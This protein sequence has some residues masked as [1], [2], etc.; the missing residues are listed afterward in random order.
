MKAWTAHLICGLII[1]AA[2][3]A[4]PAPQAAATSVEFQLTGATGSLVNNLEGIRVVL[5][6]LTTGR[7]QSAETNRQ[8]LARFPDVPPGDYQVR[9]SG[10][11]FQYYDYRKLDKPRASAIAYPFS[12]LATGAG[13]DERE[14]IATDREGAIGSLTHGGNLSD[15]DSSTDLINRRLRMH[16]IALQS[17]KKLALDTLTTDKW[18][19]Y[20]QGIID[21]CEDALEA[22]GVARRSA[23][24]LLGTWDM[25]PITIKN[26]ALCGN[27][28]YHAYVVVNQRVSET[29][30]VGFSPFN[31]DLSQADPECKF[32][33]HRQGTA[34]VDLFRQGNSIVIKYTY[35]GPNSYAD[36]RLTLQGYV[37]SGRDAS[38]EAIV[39][40]R[41]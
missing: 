30:Y 18:M 14:M 16:R 35:N 10:R 34:T 11:T 29:H 3:V 21:E 12:D 26:P 38:G 39:F 40:S 4:A 37:M 23:D 32:K 7:T 19:R 2:A 33:F 31:W 22:V 5:T 28:T 6:D 41:R 27:V 20:H 13:S 1:A 36:D 25:K 24:P 8:G 9:V 15:A 17:L